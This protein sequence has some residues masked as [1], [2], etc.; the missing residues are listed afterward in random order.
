MY[1]IFLASGG[2][3][4]THLFPSHTENGDEGDHQG[5]GPMKFNEMYDHLVQRWKP[6]DN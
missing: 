2:C 6:A 3:V 5:D 1:K 4:L